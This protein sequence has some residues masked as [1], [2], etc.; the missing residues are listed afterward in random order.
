MTPIYAFDTTRRTNAAAIADAATLGFIGDRVLDLTVGPKAGFWTKWQPKYLHTNDTDP[1]VDPKAWRIKAF[2]HWQDD[3]RHTSWSD[4]A[5]DTTV[6]DP[7]YGYRGTSRLAMDANY[8]I[9][10]YKPANAID[11]LLYEGTLEACRISR[12]TVLV[13]CQDSCVASAFRHQTAIVA[14]AAEAAGVIVAGQLHVFGVRKQP[15]DKKQLNV[16]ANYSTL[17]IL[18]VGRRRRESA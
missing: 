3:A 9:T 8:G 13:K 6:F 7:P 1:D 16:W 14:R 15:A 4:G 2:A 10:E 18:K 5:F 17:M 11:A 12:G